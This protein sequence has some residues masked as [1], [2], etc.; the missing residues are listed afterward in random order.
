MHRTGHLRH[1]PSLSRSLTSWIPTAPCSR[2]S[3]NTFSAPPQSSPAHS[4]RKETVGLS[5]PSTPRL[6]LPPCPLGPH[7]LDTRGRLRA[8]RPPSALSPQP[9]ALPSHPSLPLP[10]AHCPASG[11]LHKLDAMVGNRQARMALLGPG[12]PLVHNNRLLCE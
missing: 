1:A 3:C 6:A 9:S 10:T 11:P 4:K 2:Y 7:A 12:R 5:P 8:P